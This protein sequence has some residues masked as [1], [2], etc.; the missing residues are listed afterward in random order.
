M[1]LEMTLVV[2][3]NDGPVIISRLACRKC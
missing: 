2:P 3:L 1:A